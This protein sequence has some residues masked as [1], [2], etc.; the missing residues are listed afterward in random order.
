MSTDCVVETLPTLSVVNHL[1][2]CADETWNDAVVLFTVVAVPLDAGSLPSVV[3]V[4]LPMPEPVPSLPAIAAVIG[5][6][7]V[8]PPGHGLPSQVSELVAGVPSACAVKLV[9]EPVR[10]APFV[11][12]T[13]PLCVVA[14]PVK[15]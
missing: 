12:V 15:V 10:P 11:A 3:Y 6:V 9:P 1:I 5:E 14:E 2:V 8:Q 7:F 4:M 13:E